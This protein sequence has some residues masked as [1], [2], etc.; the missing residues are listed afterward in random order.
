MFQRARFAATSPA[1]LRGGSHWFAGRLRPHRWLAHRN[2]PGSRNSASKKKEKQNDCQ[3]QGGRGEGGGRKRATVSI[4]ITPTVTVHLAWWPCILKK[5]RAGRLWLSACFMGCR[6]RRETLCYYDEWG[7]ICSLQSQVHS[8]E[9][10]EE[11]KK[12]ADSLLR[13]NS[14]PDFILRKTKDMWHLNRITWRSFCT[15]PF[16]AKLCIS[17]RPCFR[18]F[19]RVTEQ[20]DFLE[21]SDHFAKICMTA[22]L[23]LFAVLSET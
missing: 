8:R 23:M 1:P 3:R 15:Q 22:S 21:Q 11:A 9:E 16:Y 6:R 14:R 4:L 20:F 7:G 13:W 10:C 12:P 5:N 17:C 18:L 2:E 19:R